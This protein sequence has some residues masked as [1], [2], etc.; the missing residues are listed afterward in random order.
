MGRHNLPMQRLRIVTGERA[1]NYVPGTRMRTVDVGT[2]FSLRG[3]L[4]ARWIEDRRDECA[5]VRE[6]PAVT[7]R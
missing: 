3:P 5:N 2:G 7:L 4:D 1:G 6:L